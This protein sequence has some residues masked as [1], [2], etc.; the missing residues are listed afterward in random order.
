MTDPAEDG[1]LTAAELREARGRLR[2][3]Q[4]ALAEL[5]GVKPATARQ[6]S[7]G[8]APIPRRLWADLPKAAREHAAEVE[9]VATWVE[10]LAAER[11]AD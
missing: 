3:S 10:G 2:L 7:S 8:F 1:R 11:V 4:P 6:W 9:A 5:L